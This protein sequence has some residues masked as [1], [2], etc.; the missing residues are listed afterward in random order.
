L[1]AII[2][3]HADEPAGPRLSTHLDVAAD[4]TAYKGR[5]LEGGV[6]VLNRSSLEADNLLAAQGWVP[7]LG[8]GESEV[9][10][11]TRAIEPLSDYLV[12]ILLEP[13]FV[14]Q[15]MD[16]DFAETCWTKGGWPDAFSPNAA[17]LDQLRGP[18]AA[19]LQHAKFN[20]IGDDGDIPRHGCMCQG[21]FRSEVSRS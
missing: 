18:L 1:K 14:E 13:A 8:R 7:G 12:A 19:L 11:V 9:A 6:L 21:S 10:V 20:T 17:G 3:G 5:H 15:A 16:Q 2:G 4:Y